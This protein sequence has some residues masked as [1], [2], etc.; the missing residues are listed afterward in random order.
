MFDD[1][2]RRR[3]PSL[4]KYIFAILIPYMIV[5]S[6]IFFAV[7]QTLH[8]AITLEITLGILMIYWG[9]VWLV[10]AVVKM[11][12]LKI[13]GNQKLE[14]KAEEE[15]RTQIRLPLTAIEGNA[16][17]GYAKA[18]SGEVIEF[19]AKAI[20]HQD[21][22]SDVFP[23]DPPSK[24]VTMLYNLPLISRQSKFRIDPNRAKHEY[25]QYRRIAQANDKAHSREDYERNKRILK[26]LRPQFAYI[27]QLIKQ[28]QYKEARYALS[29]IDHPKAD[30]W[31]DKLNARDPNYSPN[32]IKLQW[33]AMV[34]IIALLVINVAVSLQQ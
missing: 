12:H 24:A 32:P 21:D 31:L 15:I 25:E 17:Y 9:V 10:Y 2:L 5:S 7:F 22:Y 33:V 18:S 23:D 3:K 19:Q 16:Q 30:V 34:S 4:S 13:V 11:I 1:T 14:E 29:L 8:E 26:T 20:V 6:I 28:K 27:R